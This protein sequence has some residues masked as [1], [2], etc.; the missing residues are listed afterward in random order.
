MCYREISLFLD[1]YSQNQ[2]EYNKFIDLFDES[3]TEYRNMI[4]DIPDK[5]EEEVV[6]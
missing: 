2:D 3:V 5:I 1:M 4:K 6:E